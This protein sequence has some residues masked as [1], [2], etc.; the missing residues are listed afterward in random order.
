[1]PVIRAREKENILTIWVKRVDRVDHKSEQ[2]I[3]FGNS[4]EAGWGAKWMIMLGIVRIGQPQHGVCWSTFA[5]HFGNEALCD[6][7]IARWRKC[8]LQ[9]ISGWYA[10]RCLTDGAVI[11]MAV[12]IRIMRQG[13]AGRSIGEDDAAAD[14]F[15]TLSQCRHMQ[16]AARLLPPDLEEIRLSDIV[17]N[18]AITLWKRHLVAVQSM[19]HRPATGCH[20]GRRRARC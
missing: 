9:G 11:D 18:E 17:G 16:S 5:Q 1:M 7:C 6:G 4:V 13:R 19:T 15:D 8:D 20:A 14:M 3:G 10:A 2:P 12:T